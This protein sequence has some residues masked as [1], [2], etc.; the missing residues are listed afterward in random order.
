ML[1]PLGGALADRFDR[2]TY[3]AVGTVAQLLL[4]VVLTVLAFTHQLSVPV[5]AVVAFL[6]GSIHLLAGPAFSALLSEL[7]PAK[8]CTAR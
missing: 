3:L 1:S 6:N 2:R 7:V 4:A 8:D 5:V